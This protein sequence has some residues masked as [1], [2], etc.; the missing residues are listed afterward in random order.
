MLR[1]PRHGLAVIWEH[2]RLCLCWGEGASAPKRTLCQRLSLSLTH[3][4]GTCEVVAQQRLRGVCGHCVSE[5]LS[6]SL[7]LSLTHLPGTCEVVAQQRLRGVCGH[8]V[9][10]T[11]S[12]SLSLSLSLTHLPGTCEV[13]AQQRLRGVCGHCVAV[14]AHRRREVALPVVQRAHVVVHRRLVAHC[15]D[16]GGD[17]GLSSLNLMYFDDSG[18]HA[19]LRPV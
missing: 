17:Q 7:S 16:G 15:G 3:L 19:G 2:H 10:E 12:L 5:T 14:R 8:C 6:L 11:L 4:P 18:L 13:V 1:V 9:S